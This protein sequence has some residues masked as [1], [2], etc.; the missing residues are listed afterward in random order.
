MHSFLLALIAIFIAAKFFGALAERIGQ[1]AILGELLGGVVVGASGLRVVDP[2]DVTIHLLAQLGVIFL[3]FLIGLETDLRKLLSV[4]G[5]STV[6]ACVGVALP[7][8][9]GYFLGGFFG[10]PV[11]VRVLL[12]ASLTATSVGITARVLSDLGHLQ[13]DE[14]QVILGAAIVDDIIGLVILSIVG[15]FAVGEEVSP[16]VVLRIAGVAAAFV[17]LAVVIGSLLAPRIIA[18][19]DRIEIARAILFTAV[20]FALVLAYAA[21]RVGSSVI[22][23]AFAAGLVLA[24]GD[25]ADQIQ[26]EVRNIAHFFIPIFF[27]S[28]GAAVDFHALSARY[29]LV[30]LALTAAGIL[31]KLLAGFTATKRGL[32]RLVIGVGMMPRGE[33]G[34][35][36][37]Q[38]GLAAGILN[39]GL[40]AAVML[41]VI[42]TTFVTPLTLGLLL[43][44]VAIDAKRVA[45]PMEDV[46][47]DSHRRLPP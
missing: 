15:K 3:L 28:V 21:D 19:L 45:S 38:I 24:R 47:E 46:M 22:I 30:G 8:A 41:M 13:D 6:V 12:G 11:M 7:F 35:I 33:V 42:L 25:R 43:P 29:V 18:L 37:A 40:Y 16:L 32:R 17:V 2:N 9:A 44:R 1:P 23:G 4:G 10:Y 36:F 26:R 27:V 39:A 34:L 20:M 5:S 31:G 14:A